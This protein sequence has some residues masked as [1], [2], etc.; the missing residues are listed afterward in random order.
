[1]I[2]SLTRMSHLLPHRR[3]SRSGAEDKGLVENW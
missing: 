1:V 2:G 3:G